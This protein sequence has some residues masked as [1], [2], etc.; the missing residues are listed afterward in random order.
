[1][2][3]TLSTARTPRIQPRRLARPV[4]SSAVDLING[5]TKSALPCLTVRFSPKSRLRPSFHIPTPVRCVSL[6][7][8]TAHAERHHDEMAGLLAFFIGIIILFVC[9]AGLVWV[10]QKSLLT[11][12][13]RVIRKATD[14]NGYVA[15]IIGAGITVAVQ[16]SSITTSTLTPLVG[17]DILQLEQMYPL[18][19]GANI[20]TTMTSIMSALVTEGTDALQVALA[21]LMFNITGILIWYP[22][23]FMRAT[24]IYMARQ[25]GQA[26]R[27]WK[28]FP[29]L[30]ICIVFLL[31][32]GLFY[33]ISSLFTSDSN[34]STAIASILTVV[35][36]GGFARALYWWNYQ[37]GAEYTIK[38][39][40]T[41]QKRLDA[42]ETLAY[43]MVWM[44][45][46]LDQLH[47]HTG[48]P[49]P[50]VKRSAIGSNEGALMD[51]HIDMPLAMRNTEKLIIA[52]NLP[53][54]DD[55][56]KVGNSS[57][58]FARKNAE[59]G[60]MDDVDMEAWNRH[61]MW[62]LFVY[63][64]CCIGILVFI[65]LMFIRD[66]VASTGAAATMLALGVLFLIWRAYEFFF[67]DG[68]RKS[69]EI[70][71]EKK[72]LEEAMK[73][74]ASNIAYVKA[75]LEMLAGHLGV[76][77]EEPGTDEEDNHAIGDKLE[78][79]EDKL[80]EEEA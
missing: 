59:H 45:R 66:S 74:Y 54:E 31:I 12:S 62:V 63:L 53:Q 47:Q 22:V 23:P 73:M 58:R 70:Y 67:N 21:H 77:L 24:P 10:L 69:K 25:L 44:R 46:K 8:Y 64:C 13:T 38:R 26:T 16:S 61:H 39:L 36:V 9:L 34:A 2:T 6:F 40:V 28:G 29:V 48:C 76:E 42:K 52:A 80:K 27:H 18:T 51:I 14:I 71:T 30:Y 1:M 4:S 43:D 56:D 7:C 11:A 60:K 41:R 33:G 50:S 72:H 79:E 37:D 57:D 49:T 68:A 75:D 3:F 55:D 15:M 35:V 78:E 19:L 5:A 17:L 32:P 65:I 20:G